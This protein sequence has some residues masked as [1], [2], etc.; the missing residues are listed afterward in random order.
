MP[1]AT[2]P[3]RRSRAAAPA[4]VALA[5]IIAACASDPAHHRPALA[6]EAVAAARQ[7]SADVYKPAQVT[8]TVAPARGNMPPQY[9]EVLK[10]AGIGGVVVLS[11]VV[12]TTGL[13]DV[14]TAAVITM[15]DE[16]FLG[17]VVDALPALRF[18]PAELAGRKV[19]QLVLQPFYFGSADTSWA[20]GSQT[21]EQAIKT[22]TGAAL[23]PIK[24]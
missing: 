9:P 22:L 5:A 18:I 7:A 20:H 19:K 8:K 4:A 13:A 24:P 23:S 16:R 17:T 6:P 12:D 21:V 10:S 14:G 15:S 2:A 11:F 3:L 1:R